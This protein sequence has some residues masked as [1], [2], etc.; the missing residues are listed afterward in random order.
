[1][2]DSLQPTVGRILK[3]AL[4]I[5]ISRASYTVMLFV[6]RLF[7][8]R[9]GKHELVGQHL[10]A[11]DQ[12]GALRSVYLTLRVALLFSAVMIVAFVGFAGTLV[13]VFSSGLVDTDGTIARM[14]VAVVTLVRVVHVH[15]YIAWSTLL[16]MNNAH[17]ASVLYRFRT[18]K[19]KKI[20]LIG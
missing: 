5:V 1:M 11:K 20:K 8:S 18:G 19:W 10:G 15:P 7:L 16:I 2:S 12:D 14:T 17:A 9:V 4:P 3:I 6:D 13:S